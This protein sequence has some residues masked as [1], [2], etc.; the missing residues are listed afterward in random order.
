MLNDCDR[1]NIRAFKLKMFGNITCRTFNQVR[2]AFRHKL[3]IDSESIMIQQIK[4]LAGFDSVK[5][6]CCIHIQDQMPFSKRVVFA[7][8]IDTHRIASL[9][10]PSNTS[11]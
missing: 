3:R 9:A 5:I 7:E 11:R 8:K 6:N 10:T 4:H 1:N 2:Y